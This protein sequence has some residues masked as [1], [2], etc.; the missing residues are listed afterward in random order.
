MRTFIA[1]LLAC[2]LPTLFSI[3]LDLPFFFSP[4]GPLS[5]SLSPSRL[6]ISLLY[7]ISHCHSLLSALILPMAQ[8]TWLQML[9]WATQA[10][11]LEANESSL[12]ES[13]HR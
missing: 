1:S 7:T 10:L 4:S 5:H 6:T 8:L 9:C 11:L 13:D 3:T 2:S 12:L